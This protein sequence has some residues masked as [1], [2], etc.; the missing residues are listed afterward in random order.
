[1]SQSSGFT[2]PLYLGVSLGSENPLGKGS[3]RMRG[4]KQGGP[5]SSYSSS[6][7]DRA[8]RSIRWRASFSPTPSRWPSRPPRVGCVTGGGGGIPLPTRRGRRRI[9]L[10][11]H[12]SGAAFCVALNDDSSP[13]A[14]SSRLLVFPRAGTTRSRRPG[15]RGVF[16][17][18][19][20]TLSASAGF[21]PL[22]GRVDQ[23]LDSSCHVREL[24]GSQ[25]I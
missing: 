3:S 4:P 22:C 8:R 11:L 24:V 20:R 18:W 23:L 10:A 25:P 15:C 2:E 19:G 5:T 7:R 17:A 6:A 1:M 12:R 14:A 16:S 9:A 13:A 21:M